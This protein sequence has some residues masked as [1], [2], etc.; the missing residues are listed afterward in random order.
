MTHR[1]N[2]FSSAFQSAGMGIG[3]A[4]VSACAVNAPPI[5]RSDNAGSPGFSKIALI[6]PD[7]N[8]SQ[9]LQLNTAIGSA[10]EARGIGLADDAG[11]V[12]EVAIADSPSSVGLY[13]VADGASDEN[14]RP[15]AQIRKRRWYDACK[16]ARTKATLAVF[17]RASGELIKRSAV[18]SITCEGD[19]PPMD[20]MAELLT[21]EILSN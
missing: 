5:V 16:A 3:C 8:Q 2:R 7:E 17:D 1:R 13:A 11:A 21:A 15:I 18:E 12:G 9:R 19:A 10:F 20:E 14:A 6:A 4:L